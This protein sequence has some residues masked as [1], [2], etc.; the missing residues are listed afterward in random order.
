VVGGDVVVDGAAVVGG[1]VVVTSGTVDEGAGADVAVVLVV[2]SS[3]GC[4]PPV[5]AMLPRATR[6]TTA[7][8]TPR[9]TD[10][11]GRLLVPI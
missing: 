1:A 3:V 11:P 6:P 4:A 8:T 10:Q 5:A 7:T 2:G 9:F